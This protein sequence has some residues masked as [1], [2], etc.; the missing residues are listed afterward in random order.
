MAQYVCLSAAWRIAENEA[1][2]A[3]AGINARQLGVAEGISK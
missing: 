3:M 2:S 1:I